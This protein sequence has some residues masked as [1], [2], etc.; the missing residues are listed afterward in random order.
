LR[1]TESARKSAP[2]RR[3]GFIGFGDFPESAKKAREMRFER[4]RTVPFM[5]VCARAQL[6]RVLAAAPQSAVLMRREAA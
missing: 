4:S 2:G 6:W 3:A 5:A 1:P